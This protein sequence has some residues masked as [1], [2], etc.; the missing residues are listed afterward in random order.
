MELNGAEGWDAG[1][2]GFVTLVEGHGHVG[3]WGVYE[4]RNKMA[5][6]ICG[7]GRKVDMS[8]E[9]DLFYRDP[10]MGRYLRLNGSLTK[11]GWSHLHRPKAGF[12]PSVGWLHVSALH[13]AFVTSMA[14]VPQSKRWIIWI[15]DN[16]EGFSPG[17]CR[18]KVFSY[19]R[20]KQILGIFL[21]QPWMI[22]KSL[23]QEYR[24]EVRISSVMRMDQ[25]MEQ[26][27]CFCIWAIHT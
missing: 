26:V 20:W 22:S 9:K 1:W 10:S 11:K 27:P 19:R 25:R 12:N 8:R 23:K 17:R 21:R 3:R 24:V 5:P 6:S 13:L 16:A 14:G 4:R 7:E 18:E 2:G 15:V